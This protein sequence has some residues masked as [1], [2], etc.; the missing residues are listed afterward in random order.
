MTKLSTSEAR[1]LYFIF[2]LLEGSIRLNIE[3]IILSFVLAM[4]VSLD[5]IGTRMPLVLLLNVV[6]SPSLLLNIKRYYQV[7]N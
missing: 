4:W 5:K 6:L 7:F 3:R 2:V 1:Q